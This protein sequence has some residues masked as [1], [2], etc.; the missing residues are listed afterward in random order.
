MES[1]ATYIQRMSRFDLILRHIAFFLFPVPFLLGFAI[2][3]RGHWTAYV[4]Y[5]AIVV[6]VLA[7]AGR[8]ATRRRRWEI[9]AAMWRRTPSRFTAIFSSLRC[10]PCSARRGRRPWYSPRLP[11]WRSSP[12]L[13]LWSIL[14]AHRSSPLHRRNAS[15]PS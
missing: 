6:L 11:A 5:A 2:E 7:A 12:R 4:A 15:P 10:C 3:Y 8:I 1:L 9:S 13:T 14:T